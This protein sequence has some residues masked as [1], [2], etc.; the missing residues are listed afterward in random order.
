MAHNSGADSDT[1]AHHSDDRK[2]IGVWPRTNLACPEPCMPQC[3]QKCRLSL[4]LVLLLEPRD[5]IAPVSKLDPEPKMLDPRIK[6]WAVVWISSVYEVVQL[7]DRD[8]GRVELLR[9]SP[10]GRST[11]VTTVT[12]A[13]AG[14]P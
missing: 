10:G 3:S 11:I 13:F 12:R 2:Y 8:M 6:Q 5:G 7:A 1:Q 9:W 14:R 4:R